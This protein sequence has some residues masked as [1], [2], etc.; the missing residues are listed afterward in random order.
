MKQIVHIFGASGSGTTTL[1]RLIGQRTGWTHLDSDDYFWLPADPPF[2]AKRPREERVPLML[3]DID[4]AQNV[5]ISGSLVG[6]GDGL[7][8]HFTL[9]VRTV[10]EPAVRLERLHQRELARFGARIQPGGD[11]AQTHQAFMDWAATYD[12]GPVTTRSRAMH[13]QWQENL[14]CPVIT[15]DTTDTQR[16]LACLLETGALTGGDTR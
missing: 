7:I 14:K 13:D 10:L 12:D 6:W 2:T 8:P 4:A 11:M 15:V 1:G 3:R 9:C 16:A 5:V